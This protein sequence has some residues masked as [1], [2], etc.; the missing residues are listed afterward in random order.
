M[1]IA[2]A[3]TNFIQGINECKSLGGVLIGVGAKQYWN[4]AE[5]R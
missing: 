1:N 4:S 5:G 2:K 3:A